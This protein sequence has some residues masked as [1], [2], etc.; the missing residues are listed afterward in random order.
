MMVM[1]RKLGVIL[2]LLSLLACPSGSSVSP[3]PAD[4]AVAA[5]DKGRD[6]TG[7]RP[8]QRPTPAR[9]DPP[10]AA[11][12]EPPALDPIAQA[13]L[14]AH[15]QHR[16]NVSPAPSQP[17]PALRWSADLAAHAKKVADQ[18][19]FEH[20]KT[21]YGENLSARTG[22]V[23]PVVVVADWVAEAAN[24]DA[25]RNRCKAGEVCGHYTQ[26]IWAATTEL[27]CANSQCGKGGPFGDSEWAMTVCN[28]SPAG[29]FSGLL[30]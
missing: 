13:F 20:S 22:P 15:N 21:D 30:R 5:D 19:K 10:D 7:S 14:D 27:G 16:A 4:E 29:N 23:D 1:M 26:V 9:V 24:W 12:P 28:Y 18:C 3:Q 8:K 11:Q 6:T 25:K 2:P 17:L